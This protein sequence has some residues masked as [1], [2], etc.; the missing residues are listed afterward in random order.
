LLLAPAGAIAADL[1]AEVIDVMSGRPCQ[2]GLAETHS[3]VLQ[4]QAPSS[5]SNIFIIHHLTAPVVMLH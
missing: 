1:L 2:A 4:Y 5:P 3:S